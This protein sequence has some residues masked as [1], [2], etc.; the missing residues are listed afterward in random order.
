MSD[1][2]SIEYEYRW[3]ERQIVAFVS[4]VFK[5][6]ASSF[7]ILI[8]YVKNSDFLGTMRAGG[9]VLT[10]LPIKKIF[11]LRLPLLNKIHET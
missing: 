8:D 4:H 6:W 1:V 2:K 3:T 10:A 11:F 5:L 9:G 7:T